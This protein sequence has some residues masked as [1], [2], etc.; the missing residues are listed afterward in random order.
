[1]SHIVTVKAEVKDEMAVRAACLRLKWEQPTFGKHK[2]YVVDREG[3]GVKAPDWSYP[4]V[5]D[6]QSGQVHYDNFNGHWGEQRHLDAFMQAYAIE[7]AKLEAQKNG[8][9]VYEESLTDGSIKLTVTM[10]A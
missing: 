6:L 8:Y 9:S 7:R 3:L 5:C 1:M 4:I 10:E 2:V